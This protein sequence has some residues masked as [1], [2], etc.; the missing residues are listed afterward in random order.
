MR[1][2]VLAVLAV[3]LAFGCE[4]AKAPASEGD[5]DTQD[6]ADVAAADSAEDA[7]ADAASDAQAD[8]PAPADTPEPTDIPGLAD[9]LAAADAAEPVDLQAAADAPVDAP[10]PADVPEPA[11]VMAATDTVQPV[12]SQAPA[13]IPG[14][15][16][17]ANP[18]DA[19]PVVDSA[20]PADSAGADANPT[21]DASVDAASPPAW[22]PA[23]PCATSADCSDA[24]AKVCDGAAHVCVA[25]QTSADCGPGHL[26]QGKTCVAAVGCKNDSECKAT[27]QV[28]DKAALAC[29]DCLGANDCAVG[30]QCSGQQCVAAKA[31]KSNKECDGVCSPAGLCVACVASDDCA[32]GQ[33]CT[34]AWA[35][36]PVQCK[37]AACGGA[38]L[39]ACKVD[40]SGYE[41]GKLCND[42][43]ACTLDVCLG[44][45]CKASVPKVCDDGNPCTDDICDKSQG[46][47]AL[48]N[49]NACS[50]G[51]P[52]TLGDVCSG[53]KC[54]TG[55]QTCDDGEPCTA[56][57]CSGGQCT[58]AA[59]SG[60]C[61][62]GSLCTVG[63]QCQGGKCAG[64]AAKT[65][66]DGN[67]CT[68]DACDPKA[69]CTLTPKLNATCS[70][71]NACTTSDV[72]FQGQCV[73][74]PK[75]CDDANPCTDDTCANGSCSHA[76]NAVPCKAAGACGQCSAGVCATSL[77]GFD[78]TFGAGGNDDLRA[79]VPSSDG[80]FAAGITSSKGAGKDDG[81]L[82]RIDKDGG[83]LWDK[84]AGGAAT[85]QFTGVTALADGCAAAG[86]TDSGSDANGDGWLV[87]FD[88]TGK[89][90]WNKTY[91]DN[92]TQTLLA[93]VSY[94][95]GLAAAG[96]GKF[97]G[98]Y[99]G[100]LMGVD[101]ASG[102]LLWEE[103][104]TGANNFV[105]IA[106]APDAGGIAAGG[107]NTGKGVVL[108]RF[109]PSGA[110]AWQQTLAPTASLGVT[111]VAAVGDG[112]AVAGGL[113][114]GGAW[115][116]QDLWLMRVDSS[117]KLLWQQT[118][119]LG[120]SENFTA[121]SGLSDGGVIGSGYRYDPSTG[122]EAVSLRVDSAGTKLWEKQ[123]GG[124]GNQRF[125][126]VAALPDAYV[127]AGM[128]SSKGNGQDDGWLVKMGTGGVASCECTEDTQCADANPCSTDLCSTQ[129]KCA[130]GVEAAGTPCGP[131]TG[132]SCT[133][134]GKC[135]PSTCGNG[136]CQGLE[137]AVNC[138]VDC[139]KPMSGCGDG[140]CDLGE[141]WWTC[142]SDC[143]EPST[144]GN[145]YCEAGESSWTCPKDCKVG[146]CSWQ[147]GGKSYG[148]CYCDNLCTVFGDCCW[149]Y[150]YYCK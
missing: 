82:V 129:G 67:S 2:L 110:I 122:F 112:F 148:A 85:D 115:A 95:G 100:W 104:V 50:D 118:F 138:K 63:D 92:E 96:Y 97:S 31:C 144:C 61:S 52:C 141:A 117:G 39:F 32:S 35:C 139:A 69:G 134:E 120:K 11:D 108:V 126:A 142:P 68:L 149:D 6:S 36:A 124:T 62:D 70:D 38:A 30:Q 83:K 89:S 53:G 33:Y 44:S 66:D 131:Y 123:T 24:V 49:A 13:D 55:S 93:V 73:A 80:F 42:G 14:P 107:S 21:A 109:K 40:G 3:T 99:S 136:K 12:D 54:T 20:G 119:D 77:T 128:T 111:S 22:S 137:D 46:C 114:P 10:G 8:A 86:R 143:S 121:I 106:A 26:C 84:T 88:G 146:T 58:H 78:V 74:K 16:D 37:V 135:A 51:D 60:D 1:R 4:K 15:A 56:D 81:W 45:A 23:P 102:A 43:N 125:W 17:A 147:C 64:G 25:C 87:R 34:A 65:C 41:T 48:P 18:P 140:V 103:I 19:Q 71:G 47:V 105:T 75:D 90:L 27:Q 76:N 145:G 150:W 28:C 130:H 113:A 59:K 29:V 98:A 101:A 91:G 116:D 7:V 79:L 132:W 57:A 127:F 9:V 72:C 133:G 5:A 94:S